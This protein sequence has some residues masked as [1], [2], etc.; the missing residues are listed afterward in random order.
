MSLLRQAEGKQSFA[1]QPGPRCSPIFIV[2]VLAVPGRVLQCGTKSVQ[3][4]QKTGAAAGTSERAAAY[5][6]AAFCHGA[7]RTGCISFY[8]LRRGLMRLSC[9][10]TKI[11]LMTIDTY[12]RYLTRR[13]QLHGTAIL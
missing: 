11:S 4:D 9:A 13:M 6:L 7:M 10:S 5:N 1:V 12:I 3:E 2:T 8:D